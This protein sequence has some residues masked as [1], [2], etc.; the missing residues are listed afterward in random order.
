[1]Q[2][3]AG[4]FQFVGAGVLVDCLVRQ[5]VALKQLFGIPTPS[6]AAVDPA[7]TVPA[8]GEDVVMPLQRS[9]SHAVPSLQRVESD[10]IPELNRSRSDPYSKR[11]LQRGASANSQVGSGGGGGVGGGALAK[12]T[13]SSVG[14][15]TYVADFSAVVSSKNCRVLAIRRDEFAEVLRAFLMLEGSPVRIQSMRDRSESPDT[16]VPPPA[17]ARPVRS[18]SATARRQVSPVVRS[19]K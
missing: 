17:T 10:T 15:A 14:A 2:S 9:S 8:E 6:H 16:T 1:M 19:G 5:S 12:P 3:I 4:R 13:P 7:G 18:L 11:G